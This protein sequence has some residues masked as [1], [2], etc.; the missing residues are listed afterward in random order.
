M[1]SR[2]RKIFDF[3]YGPFFAVLDFF[4]RN[5]RANRDRLEALMS[6]KTVSSLLQYLAMLVL[7]LWLLIYAF[8]S[9][10]SRNRLTEE[11]KN[12][13]SELKSFTD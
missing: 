1:K 6:I 3:L 13:F 7:I 12:S 10:E 5:Y 2:A 4:M 8:A 9:E 11:V